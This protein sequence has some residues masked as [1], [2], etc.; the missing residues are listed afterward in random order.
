MY[1]N[2]SYKE[3]FADLHEWTPLIIETVKKDLK[4]D[5][6][7]KD[8]YFAKKFLASKNYQKATTEELAQAYQQAI[9]EEENGEEIA[10]FIAS[11]WLLKNSELYQFFEQNLTQIDPNFTDLEELSPTQAQSLIQAST[12]AFGA[13]HTYLFSVLNSVVFPQDSFQALRQQAKEKNQ[14]VQEETENFQA[15]QSLDAM[16]QGFER[17]MNRLTDKYEK[18]LAGLQKKYTVDVD[19]LKKQVAQLQRK[20]NQKSA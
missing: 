1:K 10:E 8:I 11:R 20:L 15:Q 9:A 6:L 4:N 3:K 18:K 5:H 2:A 12:D 7:K 13:P 17:E 19:T 14:Q 16:R